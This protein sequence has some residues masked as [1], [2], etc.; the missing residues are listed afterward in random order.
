MKNSKLKKCISYGEK[1]ALDNL[2][3]EHY[4]EISPSKIQDI[5]SWDYVEKIPSFSNT[6]EIIS[7]SK[8]IKK[9]SNKLLSYKK[10]VP[11]IDLNSII[12]K[13]KR[14]NQKENLTNISMAETHKDNLNQ[15]NNQA[16][17][18]SFFR[19][20]KF[21]LITRKKEDSKPPINSC[22]N[23]IYTIFPPLK[24]LSTSSQI[25]KLKKQS[26]HINKIRDLLKKESPK[27]IKFEQEKSLRKRLDKF[28]YAKNMNIQNLNEKVKYFS[29]ITPRFLLLDSNKIGISQKYSKILRLISKSSKKV[30]GN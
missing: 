2:I 15:N 1:N 20:H 22:R 6:K 4:P 23:Q 12:N 5:S 26:S 19:K 8:E 28:K 16:N 18:S 3:N 14:K 25:P 29:Q 17:T 24:N 11:K 10:L 13:V 30:S 7:S 21:K 27:C 9:D